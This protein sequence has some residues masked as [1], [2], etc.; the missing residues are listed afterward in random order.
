VGEIKI[1]RLAHQRAMSSHLCCPDQHCPIEK[2]NY[3]WS[4]K[5]F[6]SY[7]LKSKKE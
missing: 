7:V 1:Q 6:S 5:Y 3:I 4:L 2:V